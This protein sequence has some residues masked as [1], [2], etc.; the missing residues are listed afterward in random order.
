L[1]YL[2]FIPDGITYGGTYGNDPRLAVRNTVGSEVIAFGYY[3]NDRGRDRRLNKFKSVY[4]ARLEQ[5]FNP[6]TYE[7]DSFVFLDDDL[8]VCSVSISSRVDGFGTQAPYLSNQRFVLTCP[9]SFSQPEFN[10]W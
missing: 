7:V 8:G 3:V 1:E 2:A 6:F 10:I 5:V 4:P 9:G